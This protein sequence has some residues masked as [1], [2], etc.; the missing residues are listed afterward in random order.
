VQNVLPAVSGSCI[1]LFVSL[2]SSFPSHSSSSSPFYPA[3]ASSSP[4]TVTVTVSVAALGVSEM[5]NG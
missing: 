2:E 5:L 3:G 4:V 1:I